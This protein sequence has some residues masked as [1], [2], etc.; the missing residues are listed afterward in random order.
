VIDQ[1]PFSR[2]K[3]FFDIFIYHGCLNR[4]GLEQDTIL[5]LMVRRPHFNENHEAEVTLENI[6][7][8]FKNTKYYLRDSMAEIRN[9]RGR[10]VRQMVARVNLSE[11]L[12]KQGEEDDDSFFSLNLRVYHHS[13]WW[14]HDYIFE[15]ISAINVSNPEAYAP[16]YSIYV[17]QITNERFILH[18]K[19]RAHN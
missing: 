8:G 17:P 6:V 16:N 10:I 14:K 9:N 15:G 18:T 5:E 11:F 12:A 4:L 19:G 13:N 1:V 3:P 7:H 2:D